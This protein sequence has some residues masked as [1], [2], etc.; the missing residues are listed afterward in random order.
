MCASWTDKHDVNFLVQKIEGAKKSS[1][2]VTTFTGIVFDDVVVVLHSSLKFAEEVPELEQTRILYDSIFTVGAAGEITKVKLLAEISKRESS[3]LRLAE[4]NFTVVTS[5]SIEHFKE[6]QG[7]QVQ[8][9]RITFSRRMPRRFREAH[10]QAIRGQF[11]LMTDEIIQTGPG[12]N[13]H[14]PVRV[15]LRTKTDN[16]AALAAV[17][18]LTLLRGLWNYHVN[19][20]RGQTFPAAIPRKPINKILIGPAHTV[21]ESSGVLKSDTVWFETSF[22]RPIKPY[23]IQSDW[24]RIKEFELGTRRRLQRAN[25]REDLEKA[26]HRYTTALDL[27]DWNASFIQLWSLLEYLTNSGPQYDTTIKRILFVC[28]NNERDLHR[29]ILKHLRTYRNSTVHTAEQKD[30]LLTFVY[31]VKRYVEW[32][33]WFHLGVCSQFQSINEAGDYLHLP[34]DPSLLRQRLRLLKKALDYQISDIP[35]SLDSE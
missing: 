10:R 27:S 28:P 26:F 14:T 18:A 11:R 15:T 23:K 29:E 24:P 16:E 20:R 12:L 19:L 3:Y 2:G 32:L 6:L 4:Q 1:S 34:A 22:Q 35:Q 21:H 33:L 25:Y 13:S 8:G 17:D 7:A 5:M 30:D 9:C 31:Q